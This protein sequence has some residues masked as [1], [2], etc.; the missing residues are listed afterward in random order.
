MAS[1]FG[2]S[3]NDLVG[4]REPIPDFAV[5]FRTAVNHAG[6]PQAQEELSQSVQQFQRLCEDYLY[7]R[8]A[9]WDGTSTELYSPVL[10]GEGISGG[11]CRGRRLR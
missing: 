11:R 7:P 8:E 9:E 5:Q 4:D 3:V 1:I 10:H 2:R 6:S